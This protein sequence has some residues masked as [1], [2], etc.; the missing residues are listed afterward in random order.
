MSVIF[1]SYRRD[2]S[3]QLAGRLFDR[4][5]QHFGKDRVFRDIDAIEPGEK[6]AEVIAKRI[7]DCDVLVALIGNGLA[8]C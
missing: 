6:F 4:L 3:Q 8:E 1:I 7:G 5:A 2:D